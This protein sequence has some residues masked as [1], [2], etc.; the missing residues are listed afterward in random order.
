MMNNESNAQY[1]LHSNFIVYRTTK[2]GDHLI[3]IFKG[4]RTNLK[5][6]KLVGNKYRVISHCHQIYSNQ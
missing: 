5:R 3:N 4:A 2:S 1:K 6:P